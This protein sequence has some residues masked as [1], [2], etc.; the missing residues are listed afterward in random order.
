MFDMLGRRPALGRGF[1]AADAEEGNQ[2]DIVLLSNSF[3]QQRFGGDPAVVGRKI[4]LDGRACLH[5][6]GRDAAG[7][8]LSTAGQRDAVD[9]AASPDLRDGA[10]A[11]RRNHRAAA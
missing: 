8:C 6:G 2:L 5:G 4:T 3:W 11:T 10:A 7:L 1:E 9:S